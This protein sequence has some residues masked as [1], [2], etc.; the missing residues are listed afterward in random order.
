MMKIGNVEI[1]NRIILAPMAGYT[2]PAFRRIAK[3]SGAG[4]V[5]SE[6]ISANGLLHDNDKTWELV[7]TYPQERPVALQL[8]G[9]DADT[10]ARA[11]RLL[12]GRAEFDILDINMGCPVRKVLKANAGCALL[13][14]P[15]KAAQIV[16]AVVGAVN[17]PISVKIRAGVSH[18]RIN[19]VEIAR[20]VEKAGAA[21][22][23]IHGRAQTDLYRGKVNLDY[24][25]AVKAAVNIP[26]AGNGDIRSIADAQAMLDATG[27]DFLMVGRGAL[28]NP[29]LIR[30]LV[31]YFAGRTV[32][33]APTPRD[34]VEMC[35]KHF[36]LLLEEKP[37]RVAVMEMRSWTAWYLKGIENARYA[38]Q[39]LLTVKTK[40]ELEALL[41][42]II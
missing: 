21:M 20:A 14:D 33:E 30:D 3:E 2:N 17:K 8:F 40:A 25:R 19:C 7:K 10:M 5:F 12:A 26:V 28:G 16:E 29:W 11:A 18:E 6:M 38:R 23:T 4:L 1:E 42:E 15:D 36:A 24:I 37:E 22:I 13:K 41:S 34:K 32:K 31:D 35:R 9:G 27:V 39:R